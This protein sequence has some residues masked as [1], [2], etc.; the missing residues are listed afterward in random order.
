MLAFADQ[1]LSE[2]AQGWRTWLFKERRLASRTLAA[3]EQDLA[4]FIAFLSGHHGGEVTV[5]VL[6]GMRPADF[7]AWLAWRHGEDYARSSTARAMAGVRSFF[8]FIDRRHGLHNPSLRAMRTPGFNKTLP[9]PLSTG[10]I[11]VLRAAAMN[12]DGEPWVATRDLAVL[13]LLYGAG[14]RIGEATGLAR[15]DLHEGASELRVTGKGGKERVVP[16]L[17]I[18]SEALEAYLRVCPFTLDGPGPLFVGLRGKRLQASIIQ[19]RVRELRQ[20]FGL[21]ETATPHALRHSF[22]THL[23]SSGAD[24][25]AIQELLGHASLSTT[26]R[27]TAVDSTQLMEIYTRAHPRA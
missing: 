5:P 17:R 22:A 4:A 6:L 7:R 24:L 18:V 2:L 19:A 14:L 8:A 27:Y 3:Y 1:H 12:R 16:L 23:L 21:P 20:L 9:R 11:D 13:L 10:Q 26:Q 15:S 25:R